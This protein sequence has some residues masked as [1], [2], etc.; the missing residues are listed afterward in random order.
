MPRRRSALEANLP[1]P[2][3]FVSLA[4]RWQEDAINILLGYIWQGLD[5]L[6][7]R[8]Y[9]FDPAQENIERVITQLLAPEIRDAMTGAEPYYLEHGPYEDETRL[10]ANA[11]PPAYDLGFILRA[12]PR[13]IWPIEAKVLQT[14]GGVAGYVKDIRESYLSFRYA[15]FSSE[16]AMLGYLLSGLPARTLERIAERLGCELERHAHF[17]ERDHGLT[18]HTRKV[19]AGK[20]YTPEFT[21][22]HLVFLIN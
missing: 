20:D 1:V 8:G 14:E 6:K 16:A 12:N 4:N 3:D 7:A 17:P 5:G 21:C 2:G 13:A 11:Q 15:P 19:P 22:H 18:H 9:R 10:T